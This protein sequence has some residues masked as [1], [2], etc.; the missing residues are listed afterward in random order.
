MEA[1]RSLTAILFTDIV[2]STRR[3][4]ELGDREWRKLQTE[5]HSRVRKELRRFGGRE[6]NT[7]GD[8]F[9]AVFGR[10]ASAIRCAAAIRDAMK[11]LGLE[12]RSG[13]HAGEVDGK[14]R[15]L[16]GLGVHIG[17]RVAAAAAPGE[18]LVSSTVRELVVGAGFKFEDR[19]ER[20]LKG[21]PGVWHLYALSELP[22]GPGFRTGRW[23]PE[24]SYRQA[25]ILAVGALAVVGLA[26]VL[27]F[28]GR[29][30]MQRIAPE[31]A[32][33]ES[34]APG[35][36]VLPFTVNDPQLDQWREGMVDLLATNLD[37][38]GGFRAI[39]NRTVLARWEE[40][41]PEGTRADLETLLGVASRTGA[42][43]AIAGDVVTIGAGMRLTADLYDVQR[44][45]QV[46]HAQA[47]GSQD[48]LFVLVDRLSIDL[49]GALLEEGEGNVPSLSLRRVMTSSIP[50]LK[51]YLAAEG[52]FRRSDWE[53]AVAAYKEAV[54]ADS[55]FAL[56]HLRLSQTYG[57]WSET[58]FGEL[59]GIEA[60]LARRYVDRLPERE[61]LLVEIE[62]LWIQGSRRSVEVARDLVKRYPDDVDAWYLLGEVLFHEGGKHLI[63]IEQSEQAFSRALEL[64][65]R[66][67]P[68]YIH[69]VQLEFGVDADSAGASDLIDRFRE[70]APDSE[71]DVVFRITFALA[72]GSP[73]T[74]AAAL[75]SLDTLKVSC[76]RCKV[77]GTLGHPTHLN[78]QEAA[79]RVLLGRDID[80][81]ERGMAIVQLFYNQLGRG[82]LAACAELL[83]EPR[84]APG[85]KVVMAYDASL[86]DVQAPPEELDEILALPPDPQP[87]T[88]TFLIAARAAD[89]GRQQEF[90][91]GVQLFRQTAAAGYADGDSVRARTLEAVA[92]A[93]EGYATWRR[94]DAAAAWPALESAQKRVP[95]TREN[96]WI[97]WW[98]AE[99][100]AELGRPED[101]IRYLESL[102]GALGSRALYPLA[103]A[104]EAAGRRED[105]RRT[106]ELVLTAWS[107]ADPTMA[108]RVAEVR[109][110][111]AGLGMAPRG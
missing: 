75:S 44:G 36:A 8:G 101:A 13:V 14:G 20:E 59:P 10:P 39:D 110:R 82:K 54:Q 50:A 2:D 61:R 33:A 96:A 79:I 86:N 41:V 24:M 51:A 9:M 67:T 92:E 109:Q 71:D 5:H 43:Y 63:D 102:R 19:G 100:A 16:G 105:A 52:H 46:G 34:A 57:W 98:L 64:D 95:W 91:R 28:G 60:K 97:R 25:G 4:A 49:L 48:S 15:D 90:R 62:D 38:A 55:A 58:A 77:V 68:A 17:A 3:A 106:Y 81:A 1:R 111:L 21:V 89:V 103:R 72:F 84:L 42:R 30:G 107:E 45:E 65:P 27:F 12:I 53:N 6:A 76:F 88:S 94:G 85:Q 23:V 56:A 26:A 47:E 29:W 11:D 18:I 87:D 40:A 93:L 99:L 66:F 69:P 70:H 37:G 7:A 80:D 83:E 74:R 108:P 78:A 32:L 31:P 22:P 35:I 104:Y 73:D